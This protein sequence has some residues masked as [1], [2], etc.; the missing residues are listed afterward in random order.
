[1]DFHHNTSIRSI[2]EDDSVS[3]TFR[4]CICSCLGKGV[5]LWLVVRS[6]C[7]FHI[8][9]STFTSTLCFH[10][11]LIQLLASNIFM[12]EFEHGL[13]TFGTHL[14]YCSFKV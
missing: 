6:I 3:S 1:M 7:S 9:H 13:D 12:C 11:N 8:A 10:F 5:V 14:V 4:A 2:L